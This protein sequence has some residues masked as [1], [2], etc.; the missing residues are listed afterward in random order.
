MEHHS[1]PNELRG[2]WIWTDATPGQPETYGFFRKEF[3]L[4][5]IPSSAELWIAARSFF[6]VFVNGEHLGY[7]LDL[8]P[9][10]GSYAWA[11]DVSYMLNTGSNVIAVLAHNTGVSRMSCISQPDGL[12][13]QLNIDSQPFLWTNDSWQTQTPAGY[14]PNRPRRSLSSAFTEKVDMQKMPLNWHTDGVENENLWHRPQYSVPISKERWEMIPFPAPSMAISHA[15]LD[16][17]AGRGTC[18]LRHSC[19]NVSFET[20]RHAKGDGV[21]GAETFLHSRKS[22]ETEVRLY[23]D[24]PCRVFLN[25]NLVFEQGI[26]QLLPGE[27]HGADCRHCFRQAGTAPARTTIRLRD[28]WNRITV[29]EEV[30]AGTFGMAM[31]LPEFGGESMHL[32]RQPHQEAM[33]GWVIAGPLRTP[34]PNIL[35]HLVLSGLENLDFFIPVDERPVDESA[36]LESYRFDPVTAESKSVNPGESIELEQDDYIVL[37]LSQCGYGCPTVKF[38]GSAGD[39]V[40]IATSTELENGVV[41]PCVENKRNVDTVILRD[42]DSDWMACLPRGVQYVMF[43]V[44][45]AAGT[46]TVKDASVA[47]REYNFENYGRFE[48]SDTAFNRIWRTGQRTLSATVQE[49]FIDSPSRDET[50]YIADSMI[51]SWATYHVFGDFGLAAKSLEEFAH[52]QFETGEMPAGCPSSFYINIPDYALLWPVWLQQ[53]YLHTGN[54]SLLERLLPHLERLMGYF[55]AVADPDSGLL[56]NLQDHG[57]YCFLDHADIDREGTVT[58]LNALYSRALLSSASLLETSGKSP[59]AEALRTRAG[60]ICAALRHRCWNAE[61]GLFADGET[62]GRKS[63]TCSLQT[64][65]LA[66]YGGVPKSK[67]YGKIFDKLFSNEPPYYRNMPAQTNNPYFNYFILETAFALGR[68]RWACD[69]MRWYWSGMLDAGARTWWELFDPRGKPEDMFTG[70]H[71]HGYGTSPNGFLIREI[72]GIRPAKP[73]FTAVYFN[74]LTAGVNTMKA[75]VPTPYGHIMVEWELKDDGQLEAVIDA[76]YPLS[77]IPELEPDIAPSALIRVSDEV[78]VFGSAE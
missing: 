44:R 6:H 10:A 67:D 2:N 3:T 40:D 73:G 29:F 36:L 7:A 14:M 55:A 47:I 51:Q 38:N 23:A 72:A 12:W 53:H 68:R 30:V 77:V 8:C 70:S 42:G 48:S 17:V 26:A 66:I 22:T 15:Q 71:C 27:P 54:R 56:T 20:M 59:E 16:S 25:G 9:V 64:N 35:G 57:G 75:T 5:E 4:N 33:P 58:G 1:L 76:N 45:K 74:P 18:H 43:V 61:K 62:S 37:A 78:T 41:P 24:N 60:R 50:Q 13:C 28:G 65:V 19:T 39:I 31:A 69:F 34:L 49:I 32:M 11:F 63:E 21:Y 52:C 46:V